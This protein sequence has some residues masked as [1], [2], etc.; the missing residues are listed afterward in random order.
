MEKIVPNVLP[1]PIHFSTLILFTLCM[2]ICLSSQVY[3]TSD[4]CN[5]VIIQDAFYKVVTIFTCEI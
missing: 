4:K 3:G 1:Q 2:Y 5:G